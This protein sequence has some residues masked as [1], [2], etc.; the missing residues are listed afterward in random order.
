MVDL[1]RLEDPRV[2]AV[3]WHLVCTYIGT[4]THD[5]ADTYTYPRV[6]RIEN[7]VSNQKKKNLSSKQ[8][9]SCSRGSHTHV[10]VTACNVWIRVRE[11]CVCR[12]VSYS[13]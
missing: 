5:D 12:T 13:T 11:M 4:D 8:T 10:L 2:S 9:F 1:Q 6:G 7:I 3:V